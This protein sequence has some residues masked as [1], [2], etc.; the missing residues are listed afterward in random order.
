MCSLRG[1]SKCTPSSQ[2]LFV[3]QRKIRNICQRKCLVW[4][5]RLD[6]G[7][8]RL[9]HLV[10]VNGWRRADGPLLP[11][12]THDSASS[13]HRQQPAFAGRERGRIS[14]GDQ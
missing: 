4:L 12:V 14:A 1:E 8:E 2:G 11:F 3:E 9:Q 6:L 7:C 13:N 5:G 10:N